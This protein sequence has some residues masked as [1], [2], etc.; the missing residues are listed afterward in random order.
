MS[1]AS[2]RVRFPEFETTD[3]PEVEMALDDAGTLV[4]SKRWDKFYTQGIQYLAAHILAIRKAEIAGGGK[5]GGGG[6]P[7][8]SK[9]AGPVNTKRSILPMDASSGDLQ[10]ASTSYGLKYIE[11]RRLVAPVG[12]MVAVNNFQVSSL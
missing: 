3:D 2:F 12:F 11:L 10:L 1:L 9:T 5:G 8:Y 6:G 4:D 7:V